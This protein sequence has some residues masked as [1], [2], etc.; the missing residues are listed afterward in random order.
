MTYK[1]LESEL[2]CFRQYLLCYMHEVT[3]PK[4]YKCCMFRAMAAVK[5]HK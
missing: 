1:S 2:A 3:L 4:E 5:L